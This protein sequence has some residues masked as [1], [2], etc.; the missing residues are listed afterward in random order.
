MAEP[1]SKSNTPEAP[2]APAPSEMSRQAV[3][4][5]AKT[6]GSTFDPR[7]GKNLSGSNNTAVGVAPEYSQILDHPPTSAEHEQFTAQVHHITSKHTNSAVGSHHD[8][9]TG[10]H[11]LDLVG[12]TPSKV[13][14]V[15]TAQ[16]MGEKSA[17]NLA[18]DEKIPT[19]HFGPAP[20]QHLSADQRLR[21]MR[22]D[23]PK[24]ESYAG[25]HFSDKKLD[26][27]QGAHRGALGAKGVDASRS[28][29][30]RVHAG[31]KAGFGNDAPAGFYSVKAGHAAPAMEAAKPHAYSV[32][33]HFAFG[34]T[35]SP[36]FQTGYA[37]G[38][39]H[40]KASGA[41][42]KT[43]HH[44]GLNNAEHSLADAGYDG[45]HNPKHPGVRFHFG[46]HDAEPVK[47]HLH[48]EAEEPKQAPPKGGNSD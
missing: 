37:N 46:D 32:R 48:M 45:Y 22:E 18:T 19:G 12:L 13:V 33:G 35:D 17:Y 39:Q 26:K 14:A 2:Q 7:T 6:G 31:T 27:I 9:E 10:L 34:S 21:K 3:M 1:K 28:D 38:V 42:D 23:S 15:R 36:E 25:T 4:E 43:A 20:L 41:D 5:H 30:E 44:L 11:H 29:S 47:T 24:R 40:A 16:S 8:E